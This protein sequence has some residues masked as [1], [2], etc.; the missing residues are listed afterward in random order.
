MGLKLHSQQ[1][2]NL[3]KYLTPTIKAVDNLEELYVRYTRQ[4][5]VKYCT[6]IK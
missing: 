4:L 1:S 6:C 3:R 2:K 5:I